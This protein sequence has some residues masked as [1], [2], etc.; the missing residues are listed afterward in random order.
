[1]KEFDYYIFIDYSVNIIG[2]SIIERRKLLELIPKISKFSH[3]KEL[4]H[5]S[6]YI[7]SIKAIIE[8]NKVKDFFIKHKFKAMRQNMDIYL[9]VFDFIKKHQNCIIFVSID[10]HEYPNFEKFVKI[11]DGSKTIVKPESKLIK[12]TPEYRASLVLDTLL[13][14]ERL[15]NENKK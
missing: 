15:N 5:K 14:I 7:H 12:N 2:Y 6:S 1:M 9:E 13:N 8:K 4:K 3:Y 10:D 11:V